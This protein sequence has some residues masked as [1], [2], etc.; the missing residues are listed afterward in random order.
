VG[1]TTDITTIIT[2]IMIT[3]TATTHFQHL[4]NRAQGQLRMPAAP[5]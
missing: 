4:S 3:T 1:V 5:P 2:V